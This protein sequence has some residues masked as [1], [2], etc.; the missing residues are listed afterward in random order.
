MGTCPK[1]GFYSLKEVTHMNEENTV[2]Q[3]TEA[4]AAEA[5]EK[6][7]T[8]AEVDAIVGERLKRDRAKRAEDQAAYAA[9]IEEAK[10]N[11]AALESEL[12][13]MKA[14]ELV[15]QMR[16]RVA[17][18]TG[19]PTNLLTA[20]TEDDCKAQAAQI[21]AFANSNAHGYPRVADGGEVTRTAPPTT[22]QQFA[23]WFG[24]QI[25]NN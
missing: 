16:E 3:A 19:V 20:D 22:R 7:F 24:E 23:D 13:K 17:G 8:Q 15:R 12:N 4:P 5:A 21:M 9:Q 10:A 25:K 11:A 14:A 18:E 6:T 2:T 1:H